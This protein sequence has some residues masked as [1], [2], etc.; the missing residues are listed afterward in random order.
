MTAVIALTAGS[1]PVDVLDVDVMDIDVDVDLALAGD[2]EQGLPPG[3]DALGPD[4]AVLVAPAQTGRTTPG[5]DAP[6]LMAPTPQIAQT[7]V[8][9]DPPVLVDPLPPQI[10][11][12][13]VDL[14]D[15]AD[16]L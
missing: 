15:A 9:L 1:L 2:A 11:Q 12:A 6:I 13:I 14:V 8:Q 10:T 16:T 5:S 7:Y 3:P 4:A